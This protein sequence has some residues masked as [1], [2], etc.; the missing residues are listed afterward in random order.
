[1]KNSIQIRTDAFFHSSNRFRE[2]YGN[3]NPS[4]QLEVSRKIKNAFETWVN[5]D[6][7]S[8]HGSSIGFSDPTKA[9]IANISFGIKFPYLINQYFKVYTGF[10][11]S[12]SK[13]WLNN[14]SQCSHEKLSK[15]AF[16][17]VLKFGS[18]YFITRRIF[19]DLFVDY[20]Y[21]PV[22]FDTDVDIGGVKTGIGLGFK[23]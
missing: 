1:M 23:F 11:P 12:F 8:K 5:F 3:V 10:G 6:W 22:Q 17:I 7:F 15:S 14:R 21:Q 20:L 2:I 13:I 4:Y 19:L 18:C 9:S 16:G